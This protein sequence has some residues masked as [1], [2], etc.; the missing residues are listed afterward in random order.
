VAG[1]L[2]AGLAVARSRI[3]RALRHGLVEGR[4]DYF[5]IL[6]YNVHGAF[7]AMRRTRSTTEMNKHH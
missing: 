1:G 6:I 4:H 3:G 5:Q 7:T 2:A